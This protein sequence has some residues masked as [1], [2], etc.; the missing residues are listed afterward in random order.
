MVDG[1]RKREEK[2]FCL[3]WGCR[4]VGRW[5]RGRKGEGYMKRG[6]EGR[7][8]KNEVGEGGKRSKRRK[9][10]EEDKEQDWIFSREWESHRITVPTE[11]TLTKI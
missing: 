6:T 10:T 4:V 2:E 5:R 9:R 3:W 11:S 8:G 1:E 7:G